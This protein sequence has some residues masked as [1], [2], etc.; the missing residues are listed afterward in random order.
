MVKVKGTRKALLGALLLCMLLPAFRF[1]VAAY[2]RESGHEHL[3][4][5][6]NTHPHDDHI[7]VTIELVKNGHITASATSLRI[8]WRRWIPRW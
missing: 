2:L 6:F 5:L 7:A 1:Y 3:D 8:F 4:Y